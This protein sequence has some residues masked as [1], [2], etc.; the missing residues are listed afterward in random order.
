M[1]RAQKNELKL[2]GWRE[3]VGFPELGI[4]TLKAKIDTG[5]RTTALHAVDLTTIEINGE[6]WMRFRVPDAGMPKDAYCQAKLVDE[7]KIKNTSGVPELRYVI[8]TLLVMGERHWRIE[9]SLADRQKMEFQ[10]IIGRTAIRRHG[11]LVDP[12]RSFLAG[13]PTYEE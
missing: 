13:A 6:T 7:R 1:T 8:E 10:A 2:I 11:L 12:G 5:A 3:M 9:V 4:P